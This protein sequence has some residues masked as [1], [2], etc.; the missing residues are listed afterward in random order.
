M[1]FLFA[2]LS[3]ERLTQVVDVGA[4]PIDGDPPYK[5]ML[6]AGLCEVT[7]FEPQPH[8]LAR[9][10]E[11]KGPRERYLPYAL[12][13]GGEH[14]L[15]VCD[16]DGMTSLLEPDPAQLALFGRF[17][18]WGT[19]TA[20]PLV[21]TR[22][23][24][25][26]TEIRAMD[27]LKMDVQGAEREVMAHAAAR[28]K[29]TVAVQIE[30]SFIS[31]YKN[32]PSLGEMDIFMRGLGFL[33]HCFAAVKTWPLAPTLVDG[34]DNVGLN[35]LMEAD[36][37]YARDFTRAENMTPEQWKHL[38]LVAHHAYGSYDLA[39]RSLNM[40]IELGALPPGAVDGYLNGLAASR[41]S[42]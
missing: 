8:A 7:G 28:L 32:Q 5:P 15:N 6:E 18:Q 26:I 4:N 23:L 19:V 13:D 16:L 2:I 27:F 30:V 29:D 1:S 11:R 22:T 14:V 41:T 34:K 17:P 10:N 38:A 42:S 39:L 3:P 36:M 24:D 35:Q 31:L 33:P 20:R 25:S 12:G 40:L 21:P 37:V 9:L